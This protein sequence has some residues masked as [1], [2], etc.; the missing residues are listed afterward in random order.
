MSFEPSFGEPTTPAT[1]PE[2]SQNQTFILLALGLG[3]LFVVGL[4]FIGL[5]AFLIAPRQ[6][7]AREAANATAIAQ[8]TMVALAALQTAGAP[9]Q[10]PVGLG[11]ATETPL[12]TPTA[13]LV[14]GPTATTAPTNTP[15]LGPTLTFTPSPLAS[16]PTPSPTALPKSGFVEDVGLPGLILAAIGL[17]AVAVVVRRLRAGRT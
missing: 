8:Q 7:A 16:R 9:T 5:Y 10:T 2:E 4:M 11:A 14:V 12:P 15:V 3:G 13:T 17:V 1:P 6:R